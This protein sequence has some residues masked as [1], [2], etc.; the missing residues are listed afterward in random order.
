MP[1]KGAVFG[2]LQDRETEEPGSL[3]PKGTAA[4]QAGSL[5]TVL[6]Q[7][8]QAQDSLLL[9]RCWARSTH[10]LGGRRKHAC[11]MCWFRW[12]LLYAQYLCWSY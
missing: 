4:V 3:L 1:P 6:S 7:A 11:A 2:A 8:L 5:A 10:C 12:T 9:E